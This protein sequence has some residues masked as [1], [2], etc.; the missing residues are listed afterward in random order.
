ML[1][2]TADSIFWLAR[3]MERLDNIARILDVAYRLSALP[4]EDG[5]ASNEWESALVAAGQRGA[6]DALFSE[7]TPEDTIAFLT[8]DRRNPSSIRSCLEA[9][10]QNARAVRADLPHTVWEAVNEPW[11][12]M[13]P[14]IDAPTISEL[15]EFLRVAV[16]S[17]AL[18]DAACY[19]TMLRNDAF[20]FQRVGA[21]LERAD[22]TARILDVKYHLL[23]PEGSPVGGSLDHY[24]WSAIL[25]SVNARA[26]Y[27]SLYRQALR[28]WLVADLLILRPQM[29]RSLTACAEKMREYLD[30]LA[31][32][33]GRQGESQRMARAM[34]GRLVQSDIKSIYQEGLHELLTD[35]MGRN[36]ALGR[37]IS[38]QYLLG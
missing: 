21:Y 10:R 33:Y 18:F 22:A 12:A 29:P 37:S 6:Y 4:L 11:L 1:S 35:F 38:T 15:P 16:E 20:Y 19:R 2:R 28:P 5:A 27:Q 34:H 17:A 23:L 31:D 24:Q 25:R 14:R 26:N 9:A 36:A 3:Y 13:R 7:V 30:G 32:I 8:F